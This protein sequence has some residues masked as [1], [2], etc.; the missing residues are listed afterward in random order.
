MTYQEDDA[1][2]VAVRAATAA[3]TVAVEDSLARTWATISTARTAGARSRRARVL[4]PV[5][6]A[7]TVVA[8]AVGTTLVLGGGDDRG[9][10]PSA[11]GSWRER[12]VAIE[13]IEVYDEEDLPPVHVAGSITYDVLPPVGGPHSDRWQDCTGVVYAGPVAN[14][15]AV[16]SLEH[17]AVWITYHPSLSA[18]EVAELAGRVTGVD[19]LFM[20]PFPGLDAPISLQAWGY[21]LE[22]DSVADPRIDEFI[23]TLRNVSGPEAGL[24]TCGGE[25]AVTTTGTGPATL[26]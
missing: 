14:E 20:S 5:G 26:D 25:A 16:H 6:A 2:L 23:R 10:D 9:G 4:V 18:G 24:A 1:D 21:R 3:R 8:V 17:G 12:A 13:G 15:H 11:G 7:A 22:I 19:M